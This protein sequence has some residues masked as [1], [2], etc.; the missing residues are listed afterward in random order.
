MNPILSSHFLLDWY[1][2]FQF[3]YILSQDISHFLSD[4]SYSFQLSYILSQDYSHFLSD[5]SYS[6]Q[7][8]YILSQDFSHFL[9]DRSC[10]FQFNFI[11][12]QVFFLND[13][14]RFVP[15]SRDRLL[16]VAGDA[17]TIL[18]SLHSPASPTL[19]SGYRYPQPDPSA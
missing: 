17:E 3:N 19:R 14:A 10:S 12:S 7:F 15:D 11:L 2:S 8:N 1:C 13:W 9:S 5:R 6:F 18:P 16:I 4:W